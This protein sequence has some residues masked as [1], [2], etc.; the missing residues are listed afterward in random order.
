MT[1]T[2]RVLHRLPE[3]RCRAVR[4]G[5]GALFV[6]P[7]TNAMVSATAVASVVAHLLGGNIGTPFVIRATST[8]YKKID[9]PPWT[10]PNR[11]FAPVW[12]VL[13]TCMGVAV[14]R[15]LQP[16]PR[17][18]QLQHLTTSVWKEPAM[19]GWLVHAALNI[20]WAPVF[21]G[22]QRL[23]LGLWIQ[24]AMVASLVL[25][26][27]PKFASI[28]MSAALLLAPYAM[29]LLY[30]TALNWTICKLNPTDAFGYN[31]AKF[32]AGLCKLQAAAAQYAGV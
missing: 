17:R 5:Q 10:P 6:L 12:T 18:Q 21:F 8:W 22:A 28:H 4:L 19:V 16:C 24:Q 30:A 31:N 15:V 3:T 7:G 1:T 14:A 13:Y 20:A 29:W 11:V 25:F 32:Q 23:R 26:I 2:P 9:L 27:V